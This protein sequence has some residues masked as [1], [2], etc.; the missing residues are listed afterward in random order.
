MQTGPPH[1]DD[2][3][4]SCSSCGDSNSAQAEPSRRSFFGGLLVAGGAG[5]AALLGL[6]VIKFVLHPLLAK[7]TEKSWSNAGS[8]EEFKAITAPV[9]KIVQ[10]E[11]LDGWRKTV[12][13]KPIYVT[14]DAAGQLIVLSP[15]A[16]IWVA[17]CP[18]WIKRTSLFVRAIRQFLTLQESSSA[19]R[20]RAAWTAST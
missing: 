17:R 19:D 15:F 20:L 11:Q 12:S 18:G 9:K 13:E 3:I 6:P 10:I 5:V 14:K 7:T 2:N 1:A 8:V 16:P 4:E